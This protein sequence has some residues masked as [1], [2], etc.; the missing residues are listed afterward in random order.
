MLSNFGPMQTSAIIEKLQHFTRIADHK[1]RTGNRETKWE[2]Y[3][4][5]KQG[6]VWRGLLHKTKQNF[7]NLVQTIT[8][9]QAKK[10]WGNELRDF[11]WN[12]HYENDTLSTCYFRFLRKYLST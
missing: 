3:P 8:H 4:L 7:A 5:S 6:N 11:T 1:C 10:N 9:L 12:E 2:F